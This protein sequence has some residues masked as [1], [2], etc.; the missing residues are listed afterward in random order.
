MNIEQSVRRLLQE[1][2]KEQLL[3]I[4]SDSNHNKEVHLLAVDCLKV[5][6]KKEGNHS[7]KK[8]NKRKLSNS[9]SHY[10]FNIQLRKFRLD[11]LQVSAYAL[12]KDIGVSSNTIWSWES[13]KSEPSSANLSKLY[14]IFPEFE[15]FYFPR[16]KNSNSYM[17]PSVDFVF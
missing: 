4:I 7:T 8:K 9:I 5:L 11:Y 2:T 10:S 15:K 14:K 1:K 12:G 6:I 17:Y 3:S 13:G 16:E